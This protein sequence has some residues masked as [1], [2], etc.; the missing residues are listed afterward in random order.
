MRQILDL[1]I[2]LE[3][4]TSREY[5]K[6]GDVRMTGDIQMIDAQLFIKWL[7]VMAEDMEIHRG[8]KYFEGAAKSYR[9]TIN[10]VQS[11]ILDIRHS[12][13]IGG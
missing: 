11:G 8:D 10:V 3:L 7:R 1:N 12:V 4:V 13:E 2:S 6:E 5:G 9:V